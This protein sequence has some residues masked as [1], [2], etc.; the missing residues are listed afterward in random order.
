MQ[1]SVTLW[2]LGLA[3]TALVVRPA[4]GHT[5]SETF[6]TLWVSTTNVSGRWDVARRD[7]EQGLKL[8]SERWRSFSAEERERP[9]EPPERGER[10]HR[11]DRHADA[12][13]RHPPRE[14]AGRRAER[15]HQRPERELAD[16]R[17]ARS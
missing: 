11:V 5:P 14:R 16:P 15:E 4:L 2:L 8:N 1:R 17:P 13:A 9:L 12:P 6:L 3:L 7:L 10:A